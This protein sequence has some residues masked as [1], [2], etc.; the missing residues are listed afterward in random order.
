MQILSKKNI[1]RKLKILF[2]NLRNYYD[3]FQVSH[4]RKYVE[5]KLNDLS[6]RNGSKYYDN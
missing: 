1:S 2:A 4:K 5:E 3:Q 6:K